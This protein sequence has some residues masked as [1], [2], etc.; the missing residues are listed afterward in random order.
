M[1]ALLVAALLSTAPP[2]S[3]ADWQQVTP[4]RSGD[5]AQYVRQEAD[6]TTSVLVLSRNACSCDPKV[7]T[8]EISKVLLE[9]PGV[10]VKSDSEL[11]CGET[12]QHLVAVGVASA[13]DKARRNVDVFLFRIEPYMYSFMYTFQSA[14]PKAE[15]ET[16]RKTFCP[17]S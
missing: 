14:Q 15:A 1:I 9:Q 17:S 11:I 2:T 8:A 12:A 5:Y 4:T 7:A 13:E 16:K 6:G 10:T 3:A